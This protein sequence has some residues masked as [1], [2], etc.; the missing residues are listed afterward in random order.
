MVKFTARIRSRGSIQNLVWHFWT[1]VEFLLN[2]EVW[3]SLQV[4]NRSKTDLNRL[5]VPG[6][7]VAQGMTLSAGRAMP[8]KGVSGSRTLV[9]QRVCWATKERRQLTG[10]LG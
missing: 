3:I 2:L 8:C 4:L 6:L 10:E 1:L 7:K 9:L 5:A